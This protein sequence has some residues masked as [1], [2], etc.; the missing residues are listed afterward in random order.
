MSEYFGPVNNVT[1]PV[2]SEYMEKTLVE[3]KI[4]KRS[5]CFCVETY[6]T[7]CNV[8]TRQALHKR[9]LA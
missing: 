3:G 6:K 5:W 7:G 9:K 8:R 1:K 2:R 4:E